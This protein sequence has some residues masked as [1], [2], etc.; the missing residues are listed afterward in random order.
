MTCILRGSNI[1][2]IDVDAEWLLNSNAH[3]IADLRPS[4]SLRKVDADTRAVLE[5]VGLPA[6]SRAFLERLTAKL[7][8]VGPRRRAK[9]SVG[10]PV[11]DRPARRLVRQVVRLDPVEE[12][13]PEDEQA[14]DEDEERRAR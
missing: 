9:G 3:G 2:K 10:I 5:L 13:P 14:D 11:H 8:V 12:E 1:G 6:G 7:P 4:P